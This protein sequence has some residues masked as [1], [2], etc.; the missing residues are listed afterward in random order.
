MHEQ[1]ALFTC[2]TLIEQALSVGMAI[3]ANKKA[4]FATLMDLSINLK[5]TEA[6]FSLNSID[7]LYLDAYI[8]R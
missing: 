4:V 2:V 7:S 1:K 3:V 8:L 6:S 5:H